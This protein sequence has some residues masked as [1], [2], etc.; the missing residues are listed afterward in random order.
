MLGLVLRKHVGSVR[1]GLK[2]SLITQRSR[3]CNILDHDLAGGF[4]ILIEGLQVQFPVYS[5]IFTKC[6]FL[7]VLGKKTQKK[8]ESSTAPPQYAQIPPAGPTFHPQA[9]INNHQITQ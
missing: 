8:L 1:V 5:L 7:L 3:F 4:R 9:D 6:L 2:A